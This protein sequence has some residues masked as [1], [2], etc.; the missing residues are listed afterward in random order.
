VRTRLLLLTGCVALCSTVW[1]AP[2]AGT[3]SPTAPGL[4]VNPV[5]P[6]A[7]FER[8]GEP[9]DAARRRLRASPDRTP[10][11]LV[12]NGRACADCHMPTDSFQWLPASAEARF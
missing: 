2:L 11:G 12:G 4:H 3:M 6:P 1:T 5:S 9:C 10:D 7:S 8:D